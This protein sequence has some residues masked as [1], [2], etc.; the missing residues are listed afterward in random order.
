MSGAL[1]D[2]TYSASITW[3][4]PSKGV[5]IATALTGIN[6]DYGPEIPQ[7]LEKTL[8]AEFRSTMRERIEGSGFEHDGYSVESGCGTLCLN[9]DSAN[10]LW[11]VIGF[12]VILKKDDFDAFGDLLHDSI[13]KTAISARLRAVLLNYLEKKGVGLEGVELHVEDL[14]LGYR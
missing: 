8:L 1:L 14:E 10:Q 12:N 2:P 6:R 5:A 4:D 9:Q 11:V 13:L 3:I 7:P